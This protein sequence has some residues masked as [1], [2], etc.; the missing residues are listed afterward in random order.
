[1]N[2]YDRFAYSYYL[3]LTFS[4]YTNPADLACFL[5]VAWLRIPID[6]FMSIIFHYFIVG[7]V[8]SCYFSYLVRDLV[9]FPTGKGIEI[10]D[11]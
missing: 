10:E 7:N 8:V 3:C 2:S 4:P 1:M 11:K 6:L 9:D 5:C